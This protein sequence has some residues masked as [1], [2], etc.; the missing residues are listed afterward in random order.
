MIAPV[1]DLPYFLLL[2]VNFCVV[3]YFGY[4]VVAIFDLATDLEYVCISLFLPGNLV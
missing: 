4:F 1:P 3:L 2:V